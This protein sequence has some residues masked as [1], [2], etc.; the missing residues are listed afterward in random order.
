MGGTKGVVR[1]NDVVPCPKRI[2]HLLHRGRPHVV[3]VPGKD[4]SYFNSHAWFRL[5][6]RQLRRPDIIIINIIFVFIYFIFLA[7]IGYQKTSS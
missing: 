4:E 6:T 7:E 2:I 5:Q 3:F 1:T